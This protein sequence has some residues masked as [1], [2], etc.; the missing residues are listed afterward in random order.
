MVQRNHANATSA[1][2]KE[3]QS[4]NDPEIEGLG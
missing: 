3:A 1:F 2:E 4:G